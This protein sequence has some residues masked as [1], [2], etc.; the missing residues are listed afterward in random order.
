MV[1]ACYLLFKACYF[2]A[3]L[4]YPI[5][6]LYELDRSNQTDK[7]WIY[8]FFLITFFSLCE[9]TILFPLKYFLDKIDFCMFPT[10]KALFALWLYFPKKNGIDFFEEKAGPYIDKVF[11]KINSFIGVHMEKIGIKNKEQHCKSD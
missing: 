10:V 2:I 11:L 7:K 8:Y 1:C 4:G 6:S 3:I 9:S 5:K